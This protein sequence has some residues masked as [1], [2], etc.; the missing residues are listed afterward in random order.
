MEV[1]TTLQLNAVK[2]L[3]LTIPLTYLGSYWG[4][5]GIFIGIS[6]SNILAG[7]L[8][9]HQIRNLELKEFQ[10]LAKKNIL[11]DYLDDLRWLL[12]KLKHK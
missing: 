4:I 9:S 7:V 5:T 8:A 1:F 11:K 6:I 12:S 10:G 2:S 3:T